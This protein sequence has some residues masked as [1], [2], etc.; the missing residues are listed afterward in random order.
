MTMYAPRSSLDR[1][2]AAATLAEPDDAGPGSSTEAP[3]LIVGLG[4]VGRPLLDVLSGPHRALRPGPSG[5]GLPRRA[6]P[7]S[8][9][10]VQRG[11]RFG[12]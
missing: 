8:L 2:A 1:S 10:P 5:P 7:S 11:F 3:V 12:R 6:D 9:L 4:E